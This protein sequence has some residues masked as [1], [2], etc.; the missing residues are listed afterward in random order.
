MLD[1][2]SNSKLSNGHRS[3]KNNSPKSRRS[4][5]CQGESCGIILIDEVYD[6]FNTVHLV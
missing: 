1:D 6:D 3:K 4:Y 2:L 5:V